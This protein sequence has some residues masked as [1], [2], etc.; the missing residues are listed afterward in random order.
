MTPSLHVV[1]SAAHE[2]AAPTQVQ[3]LHEGASQFTLANSES[4]SCKQKIVV[5]VYDVDYAVQ[6]TEFDIVEQGEVPTL[7]SLP[8]M[9]NLRFQFDLHPDKAYLSSPVLGIKN[10]TLKVARSTHLIL[11]LLDV[12]SYMWNVKF[13]KHKKV[14]FFTDY[15]HFEFG[16]NHKEEVFALDDE[17]VMNEPEMELIRLHK[18]ERHQTFVPSS[19]LIPPEFLDSKRKTILE[20]KNGKKEVREDDWKASVKTKQFH[21]VTRHKLGEV[22][23]FSRFFQVALRMAPQWS[24][25][26]RKA[27]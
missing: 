1:Q 25:E 4:A 27:R 23:Q 18:R 16:Y 14:S 19:T 8:Q 10:M 21:C 12:C 2:L 3:R 24:K 15:K 26:K 20:F 5:C 11:D 9:R 7:M 6:S 17:W 13:E 22:G